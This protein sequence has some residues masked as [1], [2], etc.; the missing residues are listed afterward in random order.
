MKL[1]LSSFRIS[2]K[3]DKL[4]NLLSKGNRTAVIANA[5]DNLDDLE[6]KKRVQREIEDLSKLGLDGEELD[7]RN[8]FD[9]PDGLKVKFA[10]YNLV[11]VRGGNAFILRRAM[12]R[13]SFDELIKKRV[14]EDSDFVYAGYS[15]GVC[16]ITPTLRGIDL[17]DDPNLVPEGYKPDIIWDGIGFIDYSVAPHY[18]SNHPESPSIEKVVNYFIEHKMPFKTLHDGEAIVINRF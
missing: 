9:N 14:R 13:S 6:R 18:R 8:Y 2:S 7:L 10:K 5:K 16:V 4:I 12:H 15:A 17:V 3:P 1:Y 11:W